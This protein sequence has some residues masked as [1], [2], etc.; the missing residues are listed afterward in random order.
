MRS[1]EGFHQVVFRLAGGHQ[2][3][4]TLAAS[5]A[6]A[7]PFIAIAGDAGGEDFRFAPGQG[8]GALVGE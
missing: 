6:L 1:A 8:C 4:Q 2:Q 5:L 7:P 3:Q